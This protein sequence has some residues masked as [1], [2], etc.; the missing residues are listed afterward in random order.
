MGIEPKTLRCTGPLLSPL[1]N[2][3][4][5][6]PSILKFRD[7]PCSEAFPHP[8]SLCSQ[9]C[10]LSVAMET[11]NFLVSSVSLLTSFMPLLNQQSSCGKPRG[12][13]YRQ[14][15]FPL[16]SEESNSSLTSETD[17]DEARGC[18]ESASTVAGRMHSCP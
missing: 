4:Q 11:G 7:L 15:Q 5:G 13:H 6:V 9:C 17:E 1:K 2:T 12:H 3:N 10:I 8:H 16:L 18:R 14:P